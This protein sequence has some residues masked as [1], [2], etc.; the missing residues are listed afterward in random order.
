MCISMDG[1][2]VPSPSSTA[3]GGIL[4]SD[5]GR[6]I[7]AFAVNLGGG[8]ITR[9]E[10][11]GIEQG[12]KLAW[13]LGVRK[14][15]VQSDST[16]AIDLIEAASQHNP[17]YRHIVEIRQW[18]S[19]DWQVKLEHIFREAN[20]TADYLASLGHSLPVGLH[21]FDVPSSMLAHWLYFDSIGVQNPRYL[22]T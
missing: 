14:V 18:L 19:R 4:R 16:T 10:L 13:D 8:T 5:S 2:V 1:S 22:N 3:A 20:H 7:K 17:H 6:F 9:A 12:L 21:V 15:L 11:V